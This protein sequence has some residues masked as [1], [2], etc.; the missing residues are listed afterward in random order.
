MNAMWVIALASAAALGT[1]GALLG[2]RRGAKS[3]GAALGFLLG[4]FG[5]LLLVLTTD[6]LP[7][8]PA[9]S[10]RSVIEHDQAGTTGARRTTEPKAYVQRFTS[11]AD[12]RAIRR[13]ARAQRESPKQL[14][15]HA[16]PS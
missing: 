3:A 15:E 11:G 6:P 4:P 8:K 7:H 13:A 1:I 14:G 10:K 5:L 9:S 16:E 2:E 12:L